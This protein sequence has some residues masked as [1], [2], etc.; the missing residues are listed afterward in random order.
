[1]ARRSC[2]KLIPSLADGIAR[3]HPISDSFLFYRQLNNHLSDEGGS[4]VKTGSMGNIKYSTRMRGQGTFPLQLDT[5]K[6]FA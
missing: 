4:N 3:A 2:Y 1:M 6:L 5:R